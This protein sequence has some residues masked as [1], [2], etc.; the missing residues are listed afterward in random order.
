M[1]IV[2]K[3]VKKLFTMSVVATTTAWSM[4][5][6]LLVPSVAIAAE[7]PTLEAG[8]LFKVPGN[9]AVYLVNKDMK[10]M[11]FPNAEV[12]KSWYVD[13][14]GVV[15]IAT[16][17]TDNYP[18]GG[19][20]N[21]RSGSR[22]VKTVISPSVFV[23]G[24]NN[25]K[26][27]LN[28][29]AVAEAL[30]GANWAKL[31]RDLPDVF[32]ANY[33][34]G[35]QLTEAK[36]HEGQ[37]VKKSGDA[38]VYVVKDGKLVKVDGTLSAATSGD[39]RTVS[40]T[41]FGSVAMGAGTATAAS[42]VADPAQ[43]GTPLNQPGAPVAAAGS[44]V[45]SLASDT[46]KGTY[47]V[48]AAARVP[49]TKL[50]FTA[51]PD[52]DVTISSFKV[53]RAGN[54]AVNG[55]FDKVN[56]IDSEGNLLNDA[57][58]TLNSENLVIFTEDLV[59]PKG[60]TKSWTLVGDMATN[61]TGGNVPTLGL[62]SVET[63]ATVVGTLPMHGNSV[64]TNTNVALGTVTLA[65][66][67]AIGS[68]TKQVG[69][70][71]V[72][73]ASLK[74][75]V[76]TNDFQVGRLVFYNASTTEDSDVGNIKLK[77][78]NNVIATGVMKSKY[79]TFD[80]SACADDCKILKGNDKTYSVTGDIISGSARS[81]DIDI[82]KATHALVKDL[83]EGYYVTPT[84]N[85]TAMN[86]GITISQG[87]V[88]VVKTD[89][90]PSGNVAEN[91]ANVPLAS[92]NFKVTGE[93]IDI[94]TLVFRVSTTGTV[95]PTGF[96][97]ITLYNAAGKALTGAQDG[98]GA[99]SPGYATST[100][101]FTLQP[102]DNILTVKAKIDATPAENDTIMIDIDMRNSTNF[103]ARGVN[104]SETITLGT[105]ATP[106]ALVNGNTQTIK[107]SSLRVTQLPTPPTTTY[108]AGVSNILLAEVMLD[109]GAS[110]EDLKVTQFKITDAVDTSGKAIDIQNILMY[111]D[112]DGD[113][114]NGAGT[115]VALTEVKNG[116][117]TTA[118]N[119]ETYTFN[120]GGEDQ[121]LVKAGKKVVVSVR[122]TIAGGAATGNHVFKTT[123][124]NDVTATGVNTGTEVSE[125]VDTTATPSKVTVGTSG[126][127][128]QVSIDPST[129]TAKQFAGGTTGVTL[130]TF[131]FLATTTEDVEIDYL[132]LTQRVTVT[133]SA[134]YQ[135]YARIYLV[136][137]AGVTV[138]SAVPTST[139]PYI[140]LNAGAFVVRTN[141]SDGALLYLKADLS[142]IGSG[143]NVEVG[144]H[145]LGFN[146]A[147]VADVT[148]KGALTGTGSFEYLGA[149]APNGITHFMYKGL[150]TLET[151]AIDGKLAS[152]ADMYKFKLS[153]NT[154]DVGV[155]K[156]TFDIA[157]S[158]VTLTQIELYDI[159]ESNEVLLY[160]SSTIAWAANGVVAEIYLDDDE[161]TAAADAG[162]K[163]G[164]EVTIARSVPRTF[165]LRGTF[166]GVSSGDS[167]TTRI[168]GDSAAIAGTNGVAGLNTL[169][170]STAMVDSDTVNEDF[171]WS[172][173]HAA[174]HATTTGDWANGYLVN[175][176]ASVTSSA[177]VISL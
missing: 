123:A 57:G 135:D 64:T 115:Q 176:L 140:D 5:L 14:S 159:T 106:Q 27:K 66:G 71:N 163:Q 139:K 16:S 146:I 54:P 91:S 158:S 44:V 128:V 40:D 99:A 24:A 90:I 26:H 161:P 142:A 76:A 3:F 129:P 137:E 131:N 149:S 58:K 69:T 143:Q 2:V 60:T 80:L 164:E 48:D 96:D 46:P 23:V 36:P 89:L 73:L 72:E 175:G 38:N 100:D 77:Y 50:N 79:I 22:L 78:N 1:K 116:S 134:A 32:D 35:A 102:G 130:A 30:Y 177:K 92:F 148:G 133:G 119:D 169:T 121:F 63:T 165:V 112:K 151:L 6:S 109:A 93:P 113:S 62:Y 145:S 61:V 125:T 162:M 12:Y 28:D 105:Y 172:D 41:V 150:L 15:E 114:Y 86:N 74:I 45:V 167:V 59:I 124:A 7:C 47:A 87:K 103:D 82:Q 168:A 4:G 10:R 85:A 53:A 110:S 19:G 120:L 13:Y 98:V 52:A 127:T 83:K 160:S 17:C 101:T 153:A 141:D 68:V 31:V 56:V 126:G 33:A 97:S 20:V 51:G 65:Q 25:T 11:Y 21:F 155:Y 122:G 94:R 55:D 144:G 108:A 173:R 104:S 37:L 138:G 136:N 170:T 49:F 107:T 81:F 8:D 75:S 154:G 43:G 171:I 174:A 111:V 152:S 166:S 70:N 88:N 118:N 147:A 42:L 34:V 132:Y 18:S 9:S 67:V 95:I 29:P 84:N 117:D 39:V 156:L 157:T